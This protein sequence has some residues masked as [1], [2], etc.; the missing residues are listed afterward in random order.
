MIEQEKQYNSKKAGGLFSNME[1]K[2]EIHEKMKETNAALKQ[3]D[4]IQVQK[5][6]AAAQSKD[7]H[8][9]AHGYTQEEAKDKHA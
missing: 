4:K 9:G 1:Q 8:F 2:L 5:P 3:L 6:Q 7:I